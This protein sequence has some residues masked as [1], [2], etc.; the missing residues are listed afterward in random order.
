LKVERKEKL[1]VPQLDSLLK[2]F[3]R[4]KAKFPSC[5]V[6]VGYFY[7]DPKSQHA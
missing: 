3:G 6:E 7:F 2:H 4:H 1:L 5:G